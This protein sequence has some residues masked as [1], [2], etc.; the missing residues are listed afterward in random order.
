MNKIYF[1]SD[2]HFLDP[3]THFF[4]R[5]FKNIKENI[6]GLIN[7]HNEV[8]SEDDLVYFL[9]DVFF[10]SVKDSKNLSM[11]DKMNG[12]K[13]LILGNHDKIPRQEY[14]KSFDS[15]HD[16][17]IIEHNDQKF[18]L[19]HEPKDAS[20]E[21]FSLVGHVHG[22]WRV[23]KHMINVGV[24]VWNMCPVSLESILN[25]KNLIDNVYDENIFAG[26]LSQNLNKGKNNAKSY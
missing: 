19:T 10:N 26:E 25:C 16:N 5:P 7:N 17:L 12:R 4:T 20:H 8:V 1:C 24:D 21:L 23:Q 11:V 14:L 9:G 6:D 22:S 15:V 2:H 3:R 18:F 13:I